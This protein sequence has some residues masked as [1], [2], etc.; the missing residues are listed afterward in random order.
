[1]LVHHWFL[2]NHRFIRGLSP[3]P[4][5]LYHWDRGWLP[6]P[7]KCLFFV[8]PSV[9]PPRCTPC[10]VPTRPARCVSGFWT[11][12]V[13]KPFHASFVRETPSGC[14]RKKQ[15]CSS[16]TRLSIAVH[17]TFRK[18]KVL[19]RLVVSETFCC[20]WLTPPFAGVRNHFDCD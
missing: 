5:A 4:R 6:R 7:P 1:M 10:A 9:A 17:Q 11:R 18:L 15:F 20:F 2:V 3:G 13:L 14:S 16:G 19:L 12:Q 8:L